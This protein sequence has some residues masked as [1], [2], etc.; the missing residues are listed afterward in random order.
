[1]IHALAVQILSVGHVMLLRVIY[2]TGGPSALQ[3]LCVCRLHVIHAT[4]VPSHLPLAGRSSSNH[5]RQLAMFST[6]G[7]ACSC[8]QAGCR[9]SL[10][11]WLIE[12]A[13]QK[14]PA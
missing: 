11:A 14:Q 7:D 13:H 10:H 2:L 9:R 1:M 4:A 8:V 6:C 3:I 5:R 12:L